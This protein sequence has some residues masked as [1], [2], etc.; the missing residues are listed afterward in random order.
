M[1]LS[2]KKHIVHII[3]TLRRG[4]AERLVI[5]LCNAIDKK[6]F[7][8]SIV[9]FGDDVPLA[10]DL[11]TDVMIHTVYKYKKIDFSFVHR[12]KILLKS[13]QPDVV[14]THLY[15]ADVYGALA[16]KHIDTKVISTEHNI[17]VQESKLKTYI[18]KKTTK[19]IDHHVAISNAVQFDLNTRYS[20]PASYISVISN[21]VKTSR[22]TSLTPIK[23]LKKTLDLLIVGRLQKQKGHALFLDILALDPK[24]KFTLTIVG[25]GSNLQ[26]IK[27]QVKKLGFKKKVTF[28]KKSDSMQ[29][30]YKQHQIVVIPSLWE[31]FGLVAAEAMAAGRVVMASRVD[32]LKEIIN[33][34]KN[35]LLFDVHTG[36]SFHKQ[37]QWLLSRPRL[38]NQLATQAQKD[39]KEHFNI[40][41]TI[42]AYQKLYD[43]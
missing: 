41:D 12:L 24:L 19:Y 30:L 28:L 37:L 25:E 2:K 1:K 15:G 29:E 17:N 31:G 7:T 33:H 4:G 39:A 8:C 36:N 3:P 22:F 18:K 43:D 14:H 11:H 5:D 34:K 13:L 42:N 21:G 40:V 10:A 38:A 9:V 27:K 26:S 20:I 23:S 35:G 32:G 6:R 16:A